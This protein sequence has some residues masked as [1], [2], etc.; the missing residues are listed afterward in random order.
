MHNEDLFAH[1]GAKLRDLHHSYESPVH[2]RVEFFEDFVSKS[3]TTFCLQGVHLLTL[4][5]AAI[6]E[7]TSWLRQEICK[8]HKEDLTCIGS[9]VCDVTVEK[10]HVRSCGWSI[11]VKNMQNI[12]QLTMRIPD[13][14]QPPI[15][16]HVYLAYRRDMHLRVLASELLDEFC[17]EVLVQRLVCA[18]PC[19]MESEHLRLLEG[20]WKFQLGTLIILNHDLLSGWR[21]TTAIQRWHF[22]RRN[23]VRFP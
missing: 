16:W 17:G 13:H 4:V 20:D 18:V 12:L 14:N 15:F 5:V 23:I 8:D 10:V 3:T 11:R 7:N 21:H 19:V 9:T 22:V 1:H 2:P 6:N